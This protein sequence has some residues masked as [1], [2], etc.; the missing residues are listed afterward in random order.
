M[1]ATINKKPERLDDAELTHAADRI[2]RGIRIPDLPYPLNPVE[3]GQ[4]SDWRP[5]LLS[6]W[7]EQR[8]ETVIHLLNSVSVTWTVVQ[9]NAAYMADRIMDAFLE[10][11]GLHVVLA[12]QVARLRFFLA[13]RLS[14]EGGQAF[15]ECLRHWLDSLAEWRG[16][17]D[18][19]GRSSRALIDQLDG[20]VIAVAASFE[21][22]SL[23]P[24]Q[25]FCD[26]WQRDSLARGERSVKLRERLLQS[27]TG[28]ARQRRADQTAKAAVGRALSDRHLPIG[29]ADFIHDHWLSLMRQVAFTKG[30][31]AVEWRHANK[32]LEWLV[33]IGDASLSDGEDERLYQVGE[34]IGDKLTEV[35]VRSMGKA[36]EDGAAAAI[37]TVIVARLR[38]EPL[39]AD[40]PLAHRR[41]DFD[42]SWLAF[43][44]PSSG[45]VE[46]VVGRWFVEG[47]GAS[48]QRR[49][50]F[51]LLDEV[52]EVL[53]TN[54]FGVKLGTTP[55][56]E[57]VQARNTGELRILPSARAFWD[58][59]CESVSDLNQTFQS[60]LEQRQ[61]AARVARERAAALRSRIEEAE[62]RKR[63]EL[64]R[65][66]QEQERV[67]AEQEQEQREQREAEALRV[68]REKEAAAR[69]SVDSLNLG[70]WIVVANDVE[71][72]D[73][74]R[75]KLAVR[76]A[77]TQKLVFVDRLGLNRTEY[78][79]KSLIDDLVHGRARILSEA[80]EFDD[81]LSRVVGRI[82][83]GKN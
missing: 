5:L 3:P 69:Q 70:A 82:R 30:T 78:T 8:D 7:N 67:R 51:A 77:A 2:I 46:S 4:V 50:F 23:A 6:C 16:W 36:M 61:K 17:S 65:Q 62:A 34:Q 10:T 31:D 75:L 26:Q 1:S 58:V 56:N 83:V 81:T 72:E 13:W 76:I 33:W 32:L 40:A 48:E 22:R 53:W 20:M 38:G 14:E 66:R 15:D 39:E 18:S 63:E 9:V 27:E 45:D 28:M 73:P 19:G 52:N 79:E 35:W 11:S 64:Q 74:L 25:A 43:S 49:Y 24:F 68:H 47:R 29:V 12:R 54:G 55:W 60:Q 71:G 42:E 41:F 59:L 57:F 21:Q 44:K 80:A 37:E